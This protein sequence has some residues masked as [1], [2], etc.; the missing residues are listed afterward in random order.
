MKLYVW[1]GGWRGAIVILADDK[2]AALKIA[3]E[4]TY[5]GDSFTEDD[6]SEVELITNT[7]VLQC[8]G[9]S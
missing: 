3:K 8:M 4:Q 1:D 5:H 9:D 6:L 2:A 7:L